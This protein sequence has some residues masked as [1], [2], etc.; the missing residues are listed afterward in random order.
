[1]KLKHTLLLWFLFP[2]LCS[3]QLLFLPYN[4]D[5]YYKLESELNRSAENFHSSIKPYS[6]PELKEALKSESV[7]DH[8]EFRRAI[9]SPEKSKSFLF[10]P[11][12]ELSAGYETK[13]SETFLRTIAGLKGSFSYK[14]KFSAEA[15]YYLGASNL[16][17][18]QDSVSVSKLI[19]PTE[20]RSYSGILDQNWSVF[21]FNLNF[22]PSKYFTLQAGQGKFFLGEG[23]R[24]LMLSDYAPVYPYFAIHTNV[25]KFKYMNIYAL[26]D[27]MQITSRGTYRSGKKFTAMHYLSWNIH[28]NINLSFFEAEIYQ[29]RDTAAFL[30]IEPNYLNPVIF[31]RPVEYSMGSADNALLG[32]NLKFRLFKHHNIYAQVV[33][34]E[35][36]LSEIKERRGWWGN[37]FAWQLGYRYFDVFGINGLTAQAEYNYIRP[38][39]YSHG[40]VAQNYGHRQHSLAHPLGSNLTEVNG[41][42]AYRKK[43]WLVETRTVMIDYGR[44]PAG[45]NLGE[46]IY[47]SYTTHGNDFGHFTGQGI[48][49]TLLYNQTKIAYLLGNRRIQAEAGVE[50]RRENSTTSTSTM[51]VFGGLR[52]AIFN[53]YR[54]F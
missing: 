22:K 14:D 15:L 4:R 23:Y 52:T 28:K 10:A 9:E 41:S 36:L 43:R 35:F 24:S 34:D 31:Y 30:G 47:R 27:D 3:A 21:S 37:K 1:M 38:F 44:S 25:W 20:N 29:T 50:Y 2:A 48:A 51:M 39:T 45:K 42:L 26:M 12:A 11:I 6:V 16:P 7:T 46:D 17:S 19:V 33:L 49:S 40:S 54:D 13:R 5:H 32:G 18:Y 53:N 8:S